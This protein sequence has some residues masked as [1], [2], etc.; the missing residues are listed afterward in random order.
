MNPFG[1]SYTGCHVFRKGA[2][3]ITSLM[4]FMMR[5][6]GFATEASAMIDAAYHR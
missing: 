5:C 6:N 2:G 1:K 4:L 3:P